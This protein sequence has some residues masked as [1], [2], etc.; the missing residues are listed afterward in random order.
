MEHGAFQEIVTLV[1]VGLQ[2]LE[3]IRQV[4][5]FKT[6]ANGWMFEHHGHSI[7]LKPE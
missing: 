3:V 1:R 5:F 7:V 2:L 6:D 4:R